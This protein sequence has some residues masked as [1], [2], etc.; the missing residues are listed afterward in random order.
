MSLPQFDPEI[1]LRSFMSEGTMHRADTFMAKGQLHGKD[2]DEKDPAEELR[3]LVSIWQTDADINAGGS[4]TSIV[5]RA[6]GE[7]KQDANQSGRWSAEMFTRQGKFEAG[8][9]ATGLAHLVAND[10]DPTG[11]DTYTWTTRLQIKVDP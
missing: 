9:P 6:L 10:G 2:S 1:T 7:G 8:R 5:A 3:V 11:F 4:A